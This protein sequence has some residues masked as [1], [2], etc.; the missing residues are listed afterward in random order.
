MFDAVVSSSDDVFELADT[1][2]AL[3]PAVVAGSLR[4]VVV[5]AERQPSHATM[6]LIEE[7]GAGLMIAPG[8][9]LTRWQA[10]L[11]QKPEGWTLCLAA[12]IVP[13]GDWVDAVM[14]FMHRADARD[15]AVFQVAG[16]WQVRAAVRLRR[17]FGLRVIA[18]GLLIHAGAQAG[19]IVTLPAFV[20]D[21]RNGAGVPLI[22]PV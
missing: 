22:I 5:V 12:G 20:H 15:G 11:A 8:D 19:R 9:A 21:R 7:S 16:P 6:K 10:A 18:S 1:L 17:M 14:R 13:V 2:A 3:V 4:R